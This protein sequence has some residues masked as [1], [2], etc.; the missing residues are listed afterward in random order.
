MNELE[1]LREHI[2]AIDKTIIE[3]LAHRQSI[4]KEIGRLKAKLGKDILDIEREQALMQYHHQLSL[5]FALDPTFIERI[6]E[7]IMLESKQ[8]QKT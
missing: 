2:Q 7:I 1:N 4:V 3:Q 8:Q 5:T 6:F